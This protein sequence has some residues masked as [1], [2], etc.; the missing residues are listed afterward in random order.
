[1]TMIAPKPG[2]YLYPGAEYTGKIIL[3]DLNTPPSLVLEAES[4]AELLTEDLVRHVL[5]KRPPNAHKGMNGRVGI[6]AGSLATPERRNCAPRRQFGQARP[7]DYLHPAGSAPASHYQ[8]HGSDGAA[9]DG[10]QPEGLP[11]L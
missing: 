9:G 7:G 4:S 10:S 3:A 5:P 11:G 6:L 8:I 1:M 2:L